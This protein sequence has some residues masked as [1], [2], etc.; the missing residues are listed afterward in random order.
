MLGTLLT[1]VFALSPALL[2]QEASAPPGLVLIEGGDTYVGSNP[3]DVESLI[4]K[5]EEIANVFAG[6]TPRM[7]TAVE[8]FYLGVT[9][10]TNE[11]YAEFVRTT[12]AKPPHLW[13][14]AAL[15]KGR[16]EFIAT[17]GKKA[18]E[19]RA[20]GERYDRKPFD[21]EDWWEKNWRGLEWEVPQD[22]ITHPVTFVNFHDAQ[23]YATWAG[24]RLMTEFEFM[25][26][27]R[28]NSERTYPWGDE[29]KPQGLCQSREAGRDDSAPVGSFGDGAVNGVYDLVGNVWEW[30]AS[31]YTA[32]KKY[33][34]IKIK[35]KDSGG[36]RHEIMVAAGFD[37][38]MRVLVSGSFKQSKDGLR[39]TTR[40]P[41][42]RSQSAEALGFRVA[43]SKLPGLDVT[44]TLLS[45]VI[46]FRVLPQGIEFTPRAALGK[47]RWI[48]RAGKVELPG[49]AVI[50][51]HERVLFCPTSVL[52]FSGDLAKQT[53]EAPL[54]IGFVTLSH[55]LAK[56]ELD[57]ST[58]IVS[59][60][61]KGKIPKEVLEAEPGDTIPFHKVGGFDAEADCFFLSTNDGT[62]QIA[63]P[64]SGATYEKLKP[65]ALALEPYVAPTAAEQKKIDKGEL[66][67][68]PPFDTLRFG[69]TIP[70][71]SSSKGFA[72]SLPLMVKRGLIDASWH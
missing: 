72:F 49:Y 30:T 58:Y 39:V 21:Q 71:K 63:F 33:K 53:L 37:P 31:P 5:N 52:P 24:V 14:A 43:C 18:A 9:E 67:A 10:V 36:R 40:Q 11:Q 29:W 2:A 45:D 62:P 46:D 16:T 42:G 34:P 44:N 48:S 15:E 12:G 38:N 68:P 61:G 6:E 8:P 3:D 64:S 27:A 4:L 69:F 17:E 50:E 28:G 59:W 55:P 25:R 66:P 19:A 22:R 41:T 1:S 70:S 20:K 56:P 13:G 60:R 23:A 54:V 57:A 47:Q 7:K 26:A 65:G 51:G 32:F 35:T